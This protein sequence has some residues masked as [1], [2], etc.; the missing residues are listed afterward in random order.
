MLSQLVIDFNATI[1]KFK[2]ALSSFTHAIM[3]GK[4]KLMV[5]VVTTSP[6]T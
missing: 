5:G 1:I 2:F 3:I 4:A 6:R